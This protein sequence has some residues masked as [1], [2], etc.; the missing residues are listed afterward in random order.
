MSQYP[1][2]HPDL[3]K[4]QTLTVGDLRQYWADLPDDAPV[5]VYVHPERLEYEDYYNLD[6][7]SMQGVD[8]GS[9]IAVLDL[10]GPTDNRGW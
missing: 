5:I 6:G 10:S 2:V 9:P 3:A 7:G 1:E 4:C 8:E